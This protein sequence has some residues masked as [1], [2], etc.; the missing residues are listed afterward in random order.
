[1]QKA[2]SVPCALKLV[3]EKKEKDRKREN[4]KAKREFYEND[5]KWWLQVG[6]NDW[7][8]N[9]GNTAYWL[10]KWIRQVRDIDQPCPMCGAT[11]PK[12]GQWHACH[13]RSRG[14]AKQLR[15]E[16]DNIHKGCHTCNTRTE[17]DTG[18]KFRAGIVPRLGEDRVKELDEDNNIHR[19]T[20]DECREIRDFYKKLCKEAKIR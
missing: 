3:D 16:P 15:F 6:G 13:Y 9:G 7:G 11:T 14:A 17:G 20:V 1:M 12:G 4:L 18:A 2:C 5:L 8:R 19:W 10:H